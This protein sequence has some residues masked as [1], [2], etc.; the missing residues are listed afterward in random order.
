M[1][2]YQIY[3]PFLDPYYNAHLIFR[4]PKKGP[5]ILT[6]H[7]HEGPI[8]GIPGSV[9]ARSMSRSICQSMGFTRVRSSSTKE[10]GGGGGGAGG[11][12]TQSSCFRA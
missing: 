10:S 2:G 11:P 7:I 3:G 5:T 12:Q 4:V 8:E 6:T 1:S 9:T